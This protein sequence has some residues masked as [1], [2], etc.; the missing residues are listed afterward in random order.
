MNL[1]SHPSNGF[2]EDQNYLYS[3]ML[4]KD[5]FEVIRFILLE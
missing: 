1:M 2:L 5:L 4:S 3:S